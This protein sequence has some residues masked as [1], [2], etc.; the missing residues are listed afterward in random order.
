MRHRMSIRICTIFVV[1]LLEFAL[2]VGLFQSLLWNDQPR[3]PISLN[4]LSLLLPPADAPQQEQHKAVEKIAAKMEFNISLFTSNKKLITASGDVSYPSIK[5]IEQGMWAESAGK[6]RWTTILPDGRWLVITLDRMKKLNDG[7]VVT[8]LLISMALLIAL[9]TYPFIRRLT[10][11]LER[12]QISVESIGE[13]DLT[14][15]VHVEGKDEVGLLAVSFNTAAEKI[16]KLVSAQRLLLANA[17]HELRTPLTRIRLGVEM[18]GK[19]DDGDRR[20]ML[21]NDIIELDTL[22]HELMLLTRLDS[23][24]KEEMEMLDLMGLVA[25][26]GSRYQD[27][28]IEGHPMSV[29]GNLRMLQKLVRNLIDNAIIHGKAPV[30]VTVLDGNNTVRLAVMDG[31]KGI[32]ESEWGNVFEPFYR[33]KGKQNVQGYGLGLPIIKKIAKAHDATITIENDPISTITVI[34]PVAKGEA[35]N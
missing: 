27:C 21:K 26:E 3:S 34:F 15:R 12:L 2:L 4:S 35:V 30:K 31:G 16:E 19:Q 33:A 32:P 14:A 20:E 23:G 28:R 18:L 7:L 24:E 9:T 5:I 10:R 22:I 11:Q 6:T 1:S 25:E 17:S 8:T 13:G 29:S